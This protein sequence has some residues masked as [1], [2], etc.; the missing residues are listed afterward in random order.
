MGWLTEYLADNDSR[1]Y[2]TP[3]SELLYGPNTRFYAFAGAAILGLGF[4][5]GVYYAIKWVFF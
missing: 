3:D 5:A 4:W 1:G 2:D